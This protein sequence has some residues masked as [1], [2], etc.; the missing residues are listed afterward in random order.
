MPVF[1]SMLA[2]QAKMANSK[3]GHNQQA[4]RI[5]H[6]TM[7]TRLFQSLT[8]PHPKFQLKQVSMQQTFRV[9]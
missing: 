5:S 2:H 1:A 4:S 6:Q 9:A 8:L 7:N 3:V